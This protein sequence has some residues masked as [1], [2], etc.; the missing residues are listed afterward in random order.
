LVCGVNNQDLVYDVDGGL[1]FS[2]E[3]SAFCFSDKGFEEFQIGVFVLSDDVF[4]DLE[5]VF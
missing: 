1:V 4:E 5:G 3:F 2:H